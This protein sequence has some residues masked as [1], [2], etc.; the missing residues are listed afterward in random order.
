MLAKFNQN[1]MKC[2]TLANERNILA[3]AGS[4]TSL[5]SSPRFLATS[6]EATSYRQLY[7]AGLETQNFNLMLYDQSFFQ[8]AIVSSEE[9]LSVRLAYY[10]NPYI[11]IEHIN[12]KND[13]LSLLD[14][15]ELTHEEYEQL[16]SESTCYSEIPIIRYDLSTE[17]YC[18]NY[19]PTAHFHIGFNSESRWPVR[20]VLSPLA[21]FLNIIKNYYI[22]IWIKAEVSKTPLKTN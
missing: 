15:G 1:I 11:F 16:I 5:K 19:H 8:F 9:N 4:T 21:F 17:Q 18:E 22:D 7:D 20:R 13:A 3:Q 6:R 2:I 12:E 14:I 10:P